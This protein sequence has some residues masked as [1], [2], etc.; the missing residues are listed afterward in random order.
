MIVLR[1]AY[2]SWLNFNAHDGW[3]MASHVALSV[4]LA[5]FP[6][7]IFLTA[8]ASFFGTEALAQTVVRLLFET[9]PEAVAAPL[10]REIT[11]VLTGQRRDLVTIGAVLAIW[12]ASSGVEAIRVALNRA[13]GIPDERSFVR[14]RLQSIVFVLAAAVALIAYAFLVVLWPAFHAA[15][16]AGLP[17]WAQY[18]GSFDS[19]RIS[20][21]SL[22]L[23][24][25]VTLAHRF[26]PAAATTLKKVW[27]GIVAT[28]LTWLAIGALF[29]LYLA[30][31]ASYASTYAG[32]AGAM[33]ALV[34]LYTLAA[35]FVLGGE[36]NAAIIEEFTPKPAENTSP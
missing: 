24:A 12:F 27:P 31:F 2:K 9:W 17:D 10:S 28:L 6:F 29:G 16:Q 21:T 19:L 33:V 34:F 4:L 36:L 3:A 14:T 11:T 18:S 15:L 22:L 23:L 5:L 7:L 8:L 1:I 13:Y 26:L 30:Q 25:A 20:I 32:F 35:V